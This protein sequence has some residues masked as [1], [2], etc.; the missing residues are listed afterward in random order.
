[1]LRSCVRSLHLM[2]IGLTGSSQFLPA[3]TTRTCEEEARQQVLND[4]AM[5]CHNTEQRLLCRYNCS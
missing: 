4:H 1:M 2:R 5:Q 3:M